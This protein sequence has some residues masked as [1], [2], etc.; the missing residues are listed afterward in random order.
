[1]RCSFFDDSTY[2]FLR[3]KNFTLFKNVGVFSEGYI[4]IFPT[5]IYR[6]ASQLRAWHCRFYLQ[7]FAIYA[8]KLIIRCALMINWVAIIPLQRVR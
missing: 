8:E 5:F 4:W 7:K 6:T 1:M 2:H 3:L